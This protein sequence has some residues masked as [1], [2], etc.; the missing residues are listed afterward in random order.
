MLIAKNPLVN[1]FWNSIGVG[2]SGSILFLVTPWYHSRLGVEGYG[3]ITIWIMMQMMSSLFDMGIS[4]SLVRAFNS[5]SS[6]EPPHIYKLNFLRTFETIYW[7]GALLL[8]TI[9]ILAS[10]YIVNHWLTFGYYSDADILKILRIMISSV[11][12][13]IPISL[14]MAGFSGLQDQKSQNIIQITVQLSRYGVGALILYWSNDLVYFFI[15]QTVISLFATYLIRIRLVKNI[16]GVSSALGKFKS[17]LLIEYWNFTGWMALTAITALLVSNIDRIV[18]SKMV[19]LKDLGNYSL[20]FTAANVLQLSIQP[21]YRAYFP[22]FNELVQLNDSDKSNRE[23]FL[24]CRVMASILIPLSISTFFFGPDLLRFWLESTIIN[25]DIILIFRLLIVAITCS[26]I[27]WLPAAYLQ[28]SGRGS[29][30]FYMLFGALAI[31][32]PIMVF[33]IRHYGPTAA[34]TVWLIHGVSE[35]TLGLWLIHRTLLLKSILNWYKL[36]L[37]GPIIISTSTILFYYFLVG[38]RSHTPPLIGFILVTIVSIMGS[39]VAFY[40]SLSHAEKKDLYKFNYV[41]N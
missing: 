35:L 3:V 20:A 15:L 32:T 34:T 14:Y 39:I 24:S 33:F 21:F 23:Y 13:Q 9:T 38:T 25:S 7:L 1:T 27:M 40:K 18:L 11:T 29:I 16:L 4:A 6:D 8:G 10:R 17:R 12:L 31:G 36:V 28:A 26:G 37:L 19:T 30:H 22:R 41:D 2:I 5:G